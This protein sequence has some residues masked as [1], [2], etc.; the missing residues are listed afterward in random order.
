M[1]EGDDV[2]K[3]GYRKG[4]MAYTSEGKQDEIWELWDVS[5]TVQKVAIVR[6]NR[7]TC[8]SVSAVW[9]GIWPRQI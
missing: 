5:R 2:K 6:S 4:D 1:L 9:Q 8:R 3:G 7:E